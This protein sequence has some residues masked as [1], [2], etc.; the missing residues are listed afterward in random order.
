MELR[1]R[2]QEAVG[3]IAEIV[4]QDLSAGQRKAIDWVIEDLVI[5]ALRQSATSYGRAAAACCSEDEDMAHK[6]AREVEQARV[7][8][9]ANLSSLR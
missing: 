5:D 9:I 2:A 1:K 7:A 3:Q 4:G 8:L 6:I